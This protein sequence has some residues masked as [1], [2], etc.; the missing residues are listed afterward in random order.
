MSASIGDIVATLGVDADPWVRG[1]GQAIQSNRGLAD[2]IN[3]VASI[4]RGLTNVVSAARQGQGGLLDFARAGVGAFQAI[5]PF[6]GPKAPILIG[7]GQIASTALDVAQAWQ[8]SARAGDEFAAS[9]D[10]ISTAAERAASL[11][12]SDL[13]FD[14]QF[15]RLETPDQFRGAIDQNSLELEQARNS[16]QGVI[17]G[18]REAIED[19][20]NRGLTTN[21]PGFFSRDSE[22]PGIQRFFNKDSEFLGGLTINDDKAVEKI[23]AMKDRATELLDVIGRLEARANSLSEAFEGS[24]E[25]E[26]ISK[27]MDELNKIRET[28]RDPFDVAQ[29]QFSRIRDF[30]NSN[31]LDPSDAVR[32]GEK[33]FASFAA[34][35]PQNRGGGALN[36]GDINSASGVSAVQAALR[37]EIVNPQ[38]EVL[39]Q[40][41]D[42]LKKIEAQRKN[43]QQII[44]VVQE[45]A[46][47]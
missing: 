13:A 22:G 38:I 10:R 17:K 33:V 31:E 18:R 8:N 14:Q 46:I 23:N 44:N 5:A 12:N 3:N 34:G 20:I 26:R 41:L 29:K 25:T 28:G 6:T 47:A 11:K 42:V 7:L 45:G 40:Q 36:V 37:K 19:A 1:M 15:K 4:G 2:S 35:V 21:I 16:L 32:A 30:I 9:I 43:N 39:R 27:E 24:F